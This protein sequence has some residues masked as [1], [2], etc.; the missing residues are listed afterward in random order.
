MSC[1]LSEI[2]KITR[3]YLSGV[4]SIGKK[5]RIGS[6]KMLKIVQ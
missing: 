5:D 4:K 6:N 2:H 1:F 3:H